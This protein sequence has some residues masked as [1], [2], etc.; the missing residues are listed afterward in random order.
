MT[1]PMAAA[2][3]KASA[4]LG[5][6][7]IHPFRFRTAA[8]V[9]ALTVGVF[10]PDFGCK[11]GM[12]ILCRFDDDSVR[13]ALEDTSYYSSSLNPFHYEPYAREGFIRALSD[14]GWFGQPNDTPTWLDPRWRD[15]VL[16][17]GGAGE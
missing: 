16:G 5:I 10:L 15:K 3:L 14:W 6:R 17:T 12:V 1:N 9:E 4:D 13:D 2:W 11:Q 7:V 8:G